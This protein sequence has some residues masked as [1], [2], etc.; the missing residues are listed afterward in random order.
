MSSSSSDAEDELPAKRQKFSSSASGPITINVGGTKFT[1]AKSTLTSNSTYFASLLSGNWSESSDNEI[2]LDRNPSAFGKLIEYMR[3][4][5][6]KVVDIDES[7]LTLAEFLGIERLLLAVKIRWY[8]N[9]GRGPVHSTNEEIAAEFD[10]RYGGIRNAISSGLLQLFRQR[11]DVNAE[12][13]FAI[14]RIY[15][16][17]SDDSAISHLVKEAEDLFH[18]C[19]S[20]TAALDGLHLKGYSVHEKQLDAISKAKETYT[21][22]RRRHSTL[23][24]DATDIFIPGDDERNHKENGNSKQFALYMMNGDSGSEIILAPSEFHEDDEDIRSVLSGTAI[25]NKGQWLEDKGFTTR[26]LEYEELF[27]HHF[28]QP[29]SVVKFK[30]FSRM[31]ASDIGDQSW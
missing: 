4:G 28:E 25:N 31:I 3:E 8:C 27:C 22:S 24:S 12:K 18:E 2:F 19:G 5:M 9:I 16:N 11:D 10:Q 14:L 6:I 29:N 20:V 30:I 23:H 7:A 21:F 15:K 26:E 13:D 17:I 1:T